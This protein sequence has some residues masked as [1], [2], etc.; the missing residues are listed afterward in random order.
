M[1]LLEAIP[2]PVY[3]LAFVVLP[4]FGIPLTIFYLTALPILGSSHPVLGILLAW[5]AVGLNMAMTNLLTRGILHPVIEWVIRHRH[6]TIPK[7]KPHTEWKY[8]LAMRL[9]PM[10]FMFQNFPLALGH[11]RWKTYLWLSLPIQAM[12]GLAVMLVGESV[13]TGGLGYILLAAFI[14][15][16]LNLGLDYFRK[17]LTRN[18]SQPSE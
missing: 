17:L 6:L 15:L 16:I 12:I 14:L 13:L 7:F 2:K 18:P 9:S 8:V 5:T 3:F 10:P 11:A 4:T 1:A